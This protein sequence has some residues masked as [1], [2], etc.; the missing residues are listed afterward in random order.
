MTRGTDPIRPSSG[1]LSNLL[2]VLLTSLQPA[3]RHFLGTLLA[4][5]FLSYRNLPHRR[6][7]V[8]RLAAIFEAHGFSVW[9]DHGLEAGLDYKDQIMAELAIARVVAPLWCSESI[10]SEWVLQEARI[11]KDKL[12]PARLQAVT[13]PTE[14]EH[15]QAADLVAWT[16]QSDDERLHRYVKRLA[17]QASVELQSRLSLLGQLRLLP[18]LA[19]FTHEERANTM[20]K[21]RAT[22]PS[23]DRASVARRFLITKARRRETVTTMDLANW[24]GIPFGDE[25][26]GLLNKLALEDQFAD[27]PI[28]TGLVVS[29]SAG[30][31]LEYYCSFVG[32]IPGAPRDV[33]KAKWAPEIERV[34]AHWGAN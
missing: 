26:K 11:G 4:D 8:E 18:T 6:A 16:G 25:L 14:F 28:L 7:R 24:I 3:S 12:C 22:H 27:L 23:S 2:G 21:S 31:P 13:P 32:L 29:K 10:R 33:K 9:W 30:L 20:A 34:F 15:I 19:D 1:S 5:I 17:T